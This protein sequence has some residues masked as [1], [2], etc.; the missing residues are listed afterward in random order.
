MVR[1]TLRF[2]IGDRD[3]EEFRRYLAGILLRDCNV[4][5]RRSKM[6]R[7]REAWDNDEMQKMADEADA[8]DV[9]AKLIRDALSGSLWETE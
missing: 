1:M 8:L 7:E 3:P 6:L 5:E 4:K 2:D 9:E